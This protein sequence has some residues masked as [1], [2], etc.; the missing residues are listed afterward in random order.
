MKPIKLNTNNSFWILISIFLLNA[1][2]IIGATKVSAQS[3]TVLKYA[4]KPFTH[5]PRP[6]SQARNACPSQA[7]F[8]TIDGTCNNTSDPTRC[9]WGATNIP[10]FREIPAVYGQP[11]PLNS[12]NGQG[13]PNP[14]DISNRIC[15]QPYDIRSSINLTSMMFTWGQFLDHDID[16]SPEGEEDA[17]IP[18]PANDPIFTGVIPFHRSA[19]FPGT[20]ANG[21]PREQENLITSWVDASNVY[22]SDNAR[23]TWLRT[24]QNGKLKTS[25]GNL[26]PFNTTDGE[27]AS[28]IDANAPSMAGDTDF[29]GNPTKVFVAG[30]L[31]ANEQSG[32][33][34]MHT[35]FLREHNR[36]CD[37]LV[38]QGIT[39]DE[40]I[41]QTAREQVIATIQLITYYEFLPAL[42]INISSDFTDTYDPTV[43]PDIMNVFST[44][45]YRLGH[46]MVSS[47][48]PLIDENCNPVGNGSITLVEAFFNP[49]II[50]T[51]GIEPV[52]KGLSE[53][54]Q[55]EID[56]RIIDNLRNFLFGNLDLATFNIQRGRDHGLPDYNTVRFHFTG[57]TAN[58]FSDITSD[59]VFRDSL[60][61]VYGTTDDV[62]LWVGL[63]AE[64]HL[65]NSAVGATLHAILA[66]QFTR[67]RDGDFYFFT[68]NPQFTTLPFISENR[69]RNVINRNTTL[70]YP[71]L[72]EFSYYPFVNDNACANECPE[73][74]ASIANAGTFCQGSDIE[75]FGNSSQPGA[76]TT[77]T[78][79]GPGGFYSNE[80]NPVIPNCNPNNAGT[81]TL[82]VTV[83]D[84]VS[85]PVTTVVNISGAISVP[86]SGPATVAVGETVIITTNPQGGIPP[87][88]FDCSIFTG[89]NNITLVD[90]GNGTASITGVMEGFSRV[91]CFA[92]DAFGCSNVGWFAI[93]VTPP[94]CRTLDSL[95]LVDFYNATGGANWTN[96]WDLNQPMTSWYGVTLTDENCVQKLFLND[97]NIT[98]TFP[99]A[100][101]NLANLTDLALDD[102]NLTGN[103]PTAL[104]QLSN[105]QWLYMNNNDLSGP[106]PPVI[107]GLSNLLYLGL[108]DNQFTGEIPS[109][110]GGLGNMFVL[111]LSRNQLSGAVPPE[112]ANLTSLS[113]LWL[114]NNN[115]SGRVPSELTNLPSLIR[116]TLEN[117]MFTFEGLEAFPSSGI[118]IQSYAPQDSIPTTVT[119]DILSVDAGGTVANNTY[120]W[121]QNNTLIETIVGNNTFS[122]T[123]SGAY[124]CEISNS[125]VTITS[126]P[127]QNLILYSTTVFYE[128]DL[129][130]VWPGDLN[131]DGIVNQ[132]EFLYWS[133]AEGQTGA[134]RQN[135]NTEWTGQA[136]ARWSTEAQGINGKFQDANGD[137][138]VDNVDLQAVNENF[139]LTHP[140]VSAQSSPL[141]ADYFWVEPLPGEVVGTLRF[142]LFMEES[143]IMNGVLGVSG[144][145]YFSDI[146][147]TAA[148]LDISNSALRP[149][150]DFQLYDPANNLLRFAMVGEDHIN[151]VISGDDP[152]AILEIVTDGS[153]QAGE[154]VT[155]NVGGGL[156][157]SNG[158][159]FNAM[160]FTS[161]S[162]SYTETTPSSSTILLSGN[163]V[164]EQCNLPGLAE[165]LISGGTAPYTIRWNN[166]ETTSRIRNL[167]A[168]QYSVTVTD[169][170]GISASLSLDIL[171]QYNPVY[172]ADGN[173]V[174]CLPMSC[175][176]ILMLS[177]NLSGG[178]YQS[179]DMITSES[180]IQ[181]GD[182]VSLKTGKVINLESGFTVEEGAEFS[183]EMEGCGEN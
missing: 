175:P 81:Y 167:N 13:R 47:S 70:S 143:G 99:P 169:A 131:N 137:G 26:L 106:I 93:N 52:L 104:G 25:A 150:I 11:D 118:N 28:P 160:P 102:N 89:P 112:L 68:R 46:T 4:G 97:N 18:V 39:N 17:S 50:T 63:L 125:I 79:T 7:V 115:L 113:S 179:N 144:I 132:E 59:P 128:G 122:P 49:S 56:V 36:I 72:A 31:R 110:L 6:I 121:Y 42:G 108:G 55:Q 151:R 162:Q 180:L 1:L 84:C 88:T 153:L 29:T 95:V 145:I 77:Y 87:Y 19:V 82:V 21:I 43:R 12:L 96:T 61:S 129:C 9:D 57:T 105:L 75:L 154:A 92:Y 107:G 101:G 177:G 38:A 22:G 111:L 174:E 37:Q 166:G 14:R 148:T 15:N 53:Q 16:I 78:W 2:F 60:E 80:Q 76:S 83:D 34:S 130:E 35:L 158:G 62:D 73:N 98:G 138:S 51:Y 176:S 164:H 171:E 182:N 32:L 27:F 69:L 173:E 10:V 152:I 94:A 86:V 65:F 8:R 181:N 140:I 136:A 45:A 117:N 172:D 139:D 103:L 156:N 48:I 23:A 159:T 183:T 41:Y 155:I 146:P 66:E 24:F 90:N 120:N 133:I 54:N 40:T 119:G 163:V 141:Y 149:D 64:D 74:V 44:A 178:I 135:V 5:T 134:P 20:G 85:Q 126:N 123:A 142:A 33:V 165:V 71:D 3:T 109:E 161:G 100:I 170:N 67:I 30:D 58:S 116:I 147:V 127:P 168:G 91:D 124:R 157:V 114:D